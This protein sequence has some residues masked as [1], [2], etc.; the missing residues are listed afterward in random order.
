[1]DVLG[2][3]HLTSALLAIASGTVIAAGGFVIFWQLPTML[4]RVPEPDVE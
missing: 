4:N 2:L 3:V 1:M